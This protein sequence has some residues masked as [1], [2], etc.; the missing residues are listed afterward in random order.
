MQQY[1]LHS[2]RRGRL[3]HEKAQGVPHAQLMRLSGIKSMDT[4]M[5]YLD[6]GRH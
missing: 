4:W 6:K 5:R 2:F 1:T 3:Q